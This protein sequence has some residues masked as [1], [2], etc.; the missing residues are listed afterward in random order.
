[1]RQR[2]LRAAARE[3][4]ARRRRRSG[5]SDMHTMLQPRYPAAVPLPVTKQKQQC[6]MGNWQYRLSR[7]AAALQQAS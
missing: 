7:E 2:Q 4:R 3:C 6:T 5:G 1:M